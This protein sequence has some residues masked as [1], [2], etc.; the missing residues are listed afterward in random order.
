MTKSAHWWSQSCDL[1]GY[2]RSV[3]QYI[4]KRL[5]SC[6]KHAD[7]VTT[8]Y[9]QRCVPFHVQWVTAYAKVNL[10]WNMIADFLVDNT[11]RVNHNTFTH[12]CTVLK[13]W[14]LLLHWLDTHLCLVTEAAWSNPNVNFPRWGKYSN[15]SELIKHTARQNLTVFLST[16]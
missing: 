11:C 1:H 16:F 6:G 2:E 12:V 13:Y 15:T 8:Y 5:A 4:Q 3:V 10:K 14:W 7:H 9:V